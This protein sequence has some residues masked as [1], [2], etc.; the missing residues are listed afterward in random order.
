MGWA[1]GNQGGGEKASIKGVAR[2][3]LGSEKVA[4]LTLVKL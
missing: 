1:G 3:F 2:V 4:R